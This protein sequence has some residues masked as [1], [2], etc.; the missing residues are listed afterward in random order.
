MQS[1]G[2]SLAEGVSLQGG[3]GLG[4]AVGTD[5]MLCASNPWALHFPALGLL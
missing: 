4:W 1:K 3:K 5:L 2:N